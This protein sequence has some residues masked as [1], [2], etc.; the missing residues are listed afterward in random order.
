[1]EARQLADGSIDGIG[2]LLVR[3]VEKC[4]VDLDRPRCLDWQRRFVPR[5]EDRLA[6]DDEK[7]G[8]GD[9]VRSG[10]ENVF[11]LLAIQRAASEVVPSTER[12]DVRALC[13]STSDRTPANGEF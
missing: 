1:M 7:V 9:D 11:E 5:G 2:M 10:A 13:R 8:P 6:A 12:N 3:I 4:Q